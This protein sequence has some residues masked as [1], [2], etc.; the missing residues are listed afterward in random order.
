MWEYYVTQCIQRLFWS[1]TE[2]YVYTLYIY[3]FSSIVNII[4]TVLPL[5]LYVGYIKFCEWI[6]MYSG[7][8]NLIHRRRSTPQRNR[9]SNRLTGEPADNRITPDVSQ[10]S[11]VS[12]P[13]EGREIINLDTL[14]RDLLRDN[15]NASIEIRPDLFN[16][17]LS[18]DGSDR[19][20]SSDWPD[21]EPR[22]GTSTTL[23]VAAD[24]PCQSDS[25][26]S[27]PY[28]WAPDIADDFVV[29]L[30]EQQA[31]RLTR[32]SPIPPEIEGIQLEDTDFT[33]D[34]DDFESESEDSFDSEPSFSNR[35]RGFAPDQCPI[36]GEVKVEY[37]NV[38][39]SQQ[40]QAIY[41]NQQPARNGAGVL[42]NDYEE[43]LGAG[44]G[45]PLPPAQPPEPHG[46]DAQLILNNQVLVN[47]EDMTNLGAHM[48][49]YDPSMPGSLD[50]HNFIAMYEKF[51][52]NQPATAGWN[53]EA[54][55]IAMIS[56]YCRGP[57]L[58]YLTSYEAARRAAESWD[59]L[60]WAAFKGDFLK[61][62]PSAGGTQQ[63][64]EK[65][66]A[67]V[68]MPTEGIETY[69][70]T[71][72]DMVTKMNANM[73]FPQVLAYV[74]KGLPNE[75]RL[76]LDLQN[77]TDILSMSR[78]LLKIGNAYHVGSAPMFNPVQ[79]MTP[80]QSPYSLQMPQAQ[81]GMYGP[82]MT[83][84]SHSQPGAQTVVNPSVLASALELIK[85][86]QEQPVRR[87]QH[88]VRVKEEP[89]D[90][91]NTTI[92]KLA[93]HVLLMSAQLVNAQKQN[94]GKNGGNNN[95]EQ[96][97]NNGNKGGGRRQW[98]YPQGMEDRQRQWARF[99]AI[100][101][102]TFDYGTSPQGFFQSQPKPPYCGSPSQ[103]G[104]N[105]APNVPVGQVYYPQQQR[106]QPYYP[107]QQYMD[108]TMSPVTDV[109]QFEHP[110]NYYGSGNRGGNQARGG[111]GV[112][113][114]GNRGGRRQEQPQNE[115][116][117]MGRPICRKC[118]KSGHIERDCRVRPEN[119]VTKNQ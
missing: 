46:I 72:L 112:N 107:Q 33:S 110:S 25:R 34:E 104:P 86:T 2:I 90:A 22:P 7:L 85:R 111:R 96:G 102:L 4:F 100:A 50:A 15:P 42:E 27:L 93:E 37:S 39:G 16:S 95:S 49:V 5:F 24:G 8:K 103:P 78:I 118:G 69:L 114:G 94:S 71:I 91:V 28:N 19:V 68:L 77:P 32:L 89:T 97:R 57:A 53:A 70:Y 17:P 108:N 26:L 13:P 30:T 45:P 62:F 119:Y 84:T 64:E 41:S 9:R 55:R 67:R 1:V 61:A 47:I 76:Q 14:R 105:Y 6:L 74:R 73:P 81:L 117:S 106:P 43:M 88:Q 63:L 21:P 40:Q 29:R 82:P 113:R 83:Q 109:P 98:N 48:P 51:C 38:N 52:D 35:G 44:G 20:F 58:Q 3:L 87:S 54:K 12:N 23:P 18:E 11:N 66:M 116:D 59:N 31:E 10:L 75:I 65:L 79:A 36:N 92:Q 101:P 56:F 115:R 80:Y 60:T 99:H